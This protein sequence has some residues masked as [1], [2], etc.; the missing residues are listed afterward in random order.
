[1]ID[2]GFGR[3]FT[4]HDTAPEPRPALLARILVDDAHWTASGATAADAAELLCWRHAL[5]VGLLRAVDGETLG[6]HHVRGIEPVLEFVLDHVD[7]MQ[8]E[9]HP[10]VWFDSIVRTTL[11]QHLSAVDRPSLILRAWSLIDH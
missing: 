1:M 9:R 4:I 7:A 8:S 6:G 3:W 2:S 11:R 5:A 10:I